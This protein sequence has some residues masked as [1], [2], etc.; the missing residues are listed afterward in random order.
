[1]HAQAG[2]GVRD[3]RHA[4]T[5]VPPKPVSGRAPQMSAGSQGIQGMQ[6]VRGL[7][8]DAGH[9]SAVRQGGETAVGG[10]GARGKW[11]I[12]GEN[13]KADC[14]DAGGVRGN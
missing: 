12:G 7:Q 10:G 14:V 3:M 1:V 9:I 13:G 5:P 8:A 2:S 6:G 4:P 11:D